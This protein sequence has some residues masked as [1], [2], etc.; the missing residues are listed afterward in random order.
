MAAGVHS[1]SRLTC[2][3]HACSG[4]KLLSGTW[5]GQPEIFAFT[6]S[7]NINIQT[8]HNFYMVFCL[9]SS[10]VIALVRNI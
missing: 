2:S 9:S 6:F 8:K 7:V 1:C 5:S 3:S 4:S 10:L